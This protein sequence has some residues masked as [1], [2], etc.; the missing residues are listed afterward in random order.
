MN[1]V[2][3]MKMID[4]F[5]SFIARGNV[6]DLAVGV[7]IGAAFQSLVTSLTDNIIS[8]ILGCFTEV[9]FSDYTLKIG[10]LTL[11]Y[12]A[13]LTDVIN[14]IIMA[15][16][17]FLIVKFMNKLFMK[18]EIE[19]EEKVEV[20][21]PKDIQLLEEIRDLLKENMEKVEKK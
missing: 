7:I 11:R 1:K 9:D 12:G 4:E 2:K 6:L 16:I 20:V 3:K 17:V 19:S 18:K 21:V 10:T 8:P 5:R 15:F 13:F 14:F